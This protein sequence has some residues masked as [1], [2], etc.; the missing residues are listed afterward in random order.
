MRVQWFEKGWGGGGCCVC[1]PVPSQLIIIVTGISLLVSW[2]LCWHGNFF[3]L[4]CLPA[5]FFF[6]SLISHLYIGSRDVALIWKLLLSSLSL[7][8]FI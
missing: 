8:V 3:C 5:F 7:S 4:L 6:L 2:V 1:A